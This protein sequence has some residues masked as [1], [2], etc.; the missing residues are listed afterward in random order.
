MMLRKDP[1]DKVWRQTYAHSLGDYVDLY[2]YVARRRRAGE[3]ISRA[4]QAERERVKE[5][6]DAEAA[7]RWAKVVA[8]REAEAKTYATKTYAEKVRDLFESRMEVYRSETFELAL[9][10][11]EAST[12][13]QESE[14]IYEPWIFCGWLQ[15]DNSIVSADGVCFKVRVG[16]MVKNLDS[17]QPARIVV[18]LAPKEDNSASER[19]TEVPGE[20][21]LFR[22]E[23]TGSVYNIR[24]F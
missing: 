13:V 20:P 8:D 15:F 6:K 22:S 19:L 12:L 2:Q 7:A 1:R 18:R 5:I 24:D 16:D 21:G 11:S 9:E 23:V 10:H 4:K 3:A 14:E 17:D